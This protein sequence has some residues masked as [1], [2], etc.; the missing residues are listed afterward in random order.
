MISVKRLNKVVGVTVCVAALTA[1]RLGAAAEPGEEQKPAEAYAPGLGDFMAA[2]VQPHHVKV[3]LAGSA[4]NW[5][6][7]E[8]EAKELRE[9]FED[10]ATYQGVWHDY[11]I[12]KMAQA[13]LLEPLGDLDTAIGAKN[14]TDFEKAYDK[15]TAGCNAC[16]Q[17]TGNEFI[18]LKAPAGMDFPDQDFQPR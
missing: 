4:K 13:T 8:Y 7:A 3:W 18:V 12:A 17:A 10:I 6:L 9:T 15:V 16:H 14:A 1:G 11:P 5:P 2:Y